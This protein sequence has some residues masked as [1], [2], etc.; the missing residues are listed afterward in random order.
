MSTHT[1]TTCAAGHILNANTGGLRCST[2]QKELKKTIKSYP[3]NKMYEIT[4]QLISVKRLYVFN[5]HVLQYVILQKQYF[6]R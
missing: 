4:Q 5:T 2:D 3:Q 1:A 6:I